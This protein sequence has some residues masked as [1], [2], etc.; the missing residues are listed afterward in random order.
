MA[1]RQRA[2]PVRSAQ[3]DCENDMYSVKT[4]DE[5]SPDVLE[6][7]QQCINKMQQLFQECIKSDKDGKGLPREAPGDLLYTAKTKWLF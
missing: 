3:L 5:M 2:I 6:E 4:A 7:L 1:S